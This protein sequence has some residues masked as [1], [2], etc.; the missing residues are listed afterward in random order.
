MKAALLPLTAALLGFGTVG[1]LV[2]VAP[3]GEAQAQ[4]QRGG[5]NAA[6]RNYVRR[7]GA[8]DMYEIQ[9]SEIALRRARRPEIREMAQMLIRDHR[10]TTAE[11]AQAAREDDVPMMPPMLE[12]AQRSMIR[13]LERVAPGAFDRL[14]ITQQVTAHSQALA[15]H[16]G[17]SR[18]GDARALRRAAMGAVPV[19]QGHLTHARRLQRLR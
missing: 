2:P 3:D 15:L 19:I 6:T 17:Y 18:S 12:P 14:Y 13:Q 7:A 8:A 9:S 4:M 5:H 11:V 10:R 1:M 16:R